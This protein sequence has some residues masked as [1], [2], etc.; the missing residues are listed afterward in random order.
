LTIQEFAEWAEDRDKAITGDTEGDSG[1]EGIAFVRDGDNNLAKIVFPEQPPSSS[2]LICLSLVPAMLASWMK[3]CVSA[4]TSHEKHH[5]AYL[6]YVLEKKYK[7]YKVPGANNRKL[8]HIHIFISRSDWF[9]FPRNKDL[10]PPLL[11]MFHKEC[12]D[13]K[14]LNFSP[15]NQS[16]QRTYDSLNQNSPYVGYI[17]R[18]S[19]LTAGM[20]LEELTKRI[21]SDAIKSHVGS[22]L[23]VIGTGVNLPERKFIFL[24]TSPY[25]PSSAFWFA[26]SVG[27][28]QHHMLQDLITTCIQNLGR[29]TRFT[30]KEEKSKVEARRVVFPVNPKETPGSPPM[31]LE[32]VK[33]NFEN[34]GVTRLDDLGEKFS[35]LQRR[36]GREGQVAMKA[37]LKADKE[38]AEL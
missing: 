11:E 10:W 16:A 15:N 5:L 9:N 3:P 26:E 20:C 19:E 8:N 6:Q 28:A 29:F 12:V 37:K 4:S 2:D 25:G 7:P 14:V 22:S 31:L 27:G 13:R 33:E 32:L 21:D 24:Q 38:K 30:Q 18:S 1:D 35:N 17:E 23:G 34:V 36:R